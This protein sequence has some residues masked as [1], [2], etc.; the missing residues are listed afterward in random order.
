MNFTL[1]FKLVGKTLMVEA[2]ALLLPLLV[3]LFY[4]EDPRPF[5][6]TIRLMLVGLA[7]SLLRSNGT[8]SPERAFLPWPS[9]GC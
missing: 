8:F 3:A 6:L 1:V 9:S 2:C 5:L 7:L 4:G